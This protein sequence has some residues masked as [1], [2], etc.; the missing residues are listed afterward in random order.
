MKNIIVVICLAF[1][2]TFA[3]AQRVGL[4]ANRALFQGYGS[5]AITPELNTVGLSYSRKII[6]LLGIHVAA[7]LNY[8]DSKIFGTLVT[9]HGFT[10]TISQF[11]ANARVEWRPLYG[12]IVHPIVGYSFGYSQVQK[13]VSNGTSDLV[14]NA[15]YYPSGLVLGVGAKLFG[16]RFD[17]TSSLIKNGNISL[18][19]Y[20][21]D[22][23]DINKAYTDTAIPLSLRNYT[24]RVSFP[25]NTKE[26]QIVGKMRN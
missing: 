7:S 9:N 13:S 17:L 10:E 8:G 18:P 14:K 24:L 15:T 6:S 16:I 5:T 26:K 20:S 1:V 11:G 19:V 22:N 21:S 25:I 12:F 4:E 3:H 23:T 2:A